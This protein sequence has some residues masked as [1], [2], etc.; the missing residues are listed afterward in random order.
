MAMFSREQ[1]HVLHNNQLAEV[2][3]QLRFPE[4]LMIGQRPPADFQEMIRDEFPQYSAK[5]EFPAPKISGTPGNLT[6]ENQAPGI[7]YQ[8]ISAD[9]VWRI[10]LTS[11]FLSLACSRYT[12]W[13]DFAKRLD[14][15]LAAFIQIYRPAYFQRVGLRYLNFISRNSLNLNEFP[16]R[17]LIQSAYLGPLGEEDIAESAAFRCTVDTELQIRGGCRV[18][19]HAGPGLVKR[20]NHND[21]EVRFI[22]D[23]DLYMTGNVPVNYSAGALETLHAQAYSI[24]RGAITDTLFDAMEPEPI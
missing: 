22:F 5:K 4:I 17:D 18:K 14:K 23:Q 10:N 21:K 3:C 24:F 9:G 13:E 19:I 1:R 20:K 8:F 6:V 16:Y 12:R 15:P 11:N 7:N 2:I